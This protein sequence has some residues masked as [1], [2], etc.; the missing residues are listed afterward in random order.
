MMMMM[1]LSYMGTASRY[2]TAFGL[3][4]NFAFFFSDSFLI[5]Y[6]CTCS[7]A[8]NKK[9]YLFKLYIYIYTYD[10]IRSILLVID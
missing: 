9:S 10:Y 4:F 6:Y 2:L 3:A 5:L 7:F 1:L 8:P